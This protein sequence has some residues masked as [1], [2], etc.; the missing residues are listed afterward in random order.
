MRIM[1]KDL[2]ENKKKKWLMRTSFSRLWG[3]NRISQAYLLLQI[4]KQAHYIL[5]YIMVN[6]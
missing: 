6:Y 5:Y 3:K 1:V 4:K 2:G